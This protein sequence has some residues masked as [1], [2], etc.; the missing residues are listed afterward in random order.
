[1]TG[2]DR[3]RYALISGKL[4][5]VTADWEP[6]KPG[7][8]VVGSLVLAA[9]P[10][11]LGHLYV[12]EKYLPDGK[13]VGTLHTDESR[14]LRVLGLD[15]TH[16]AWCGGRCFHGEEPV[17]HW[18]LIIKLGQGLYTAAYKAGASL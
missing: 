1:M 4:R 11:L 12:W 17:L 13:H 14:P 6:S 15:H 16:G 2:T 8:R 5:D 3:T 10:G 9:R 18:H 7:D